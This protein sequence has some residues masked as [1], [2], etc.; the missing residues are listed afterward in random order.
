MFG[1]GRRKTR[2]QRMREELS[3]GLDHLMQAAT[4]AAGEVGATVGPR[5]NAAR[6]RLAPKAD[7]MR[8]AASQGWGTTVTALAPLAAA[9]REGAQKTGGTARRAKA[10]GL[11][12]GA[13]GARAIGVKKKG[14]RMSRK[15]GFMLTGLLAAGVAAGATGALVMRRRRQ[16]RWEEYDPNQALEDNAMRTQAVA[17]SARSTFDS[18]MDSAASGAQR[19]AAG[20][21]RAAD[22]LTASTG[23]AAGKATSTAAS[24]KEKNQQSG[25]VISGSPSHNSRN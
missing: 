7:R 14:P 6:D 2:S 17:S 15:R 13:R 20:V 1:I 5:V 11:K 9:A 3:E 18:A 25:G 23:K 16:Q 22:K 4:H 19:I 10:K 21:D 8:D 24:A 12:A